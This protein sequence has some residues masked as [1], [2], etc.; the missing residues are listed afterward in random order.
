MAREDPALAR[1]PARRHGL[2]RLHAGARARVERA[3]ATTSPSSARSRTPSAT[4]SAAREVVR[5]DVGGLLPVFVL[6]RY[7]G[8]EVKL[9]QECSRAEL[10]D[11]VERERGR[12]PRAAAGRPRLREPR[13]PRRPG[14]RRDRRAA[15]PSRRTARS[16]STRCA[17]TPSS[18]PGG[19]RRSTGAEAVFVGSAHI[20]EVL[21]D[22]VGHVDRVH[23]VPPGVDIDEWRPRPRDEAL[24]GLLAEARRD[25]PNPGNASERLPDEGNAERLADVPRRRRARPSSTSGSSSTTRASTSCSR[26]CA[27]V[28]ARAVIVGFGDYREELERARRPAHALHRPAR[29]PAPRPPARARGRH[30]RPVDL[31]GG[32]RD[33]RRRGRRR[34]LAAARR[35]PLRPRRDRGGPGAG[36]PAAPA[37]T[38]RASRPA[39]RRSSRAS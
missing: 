7:E 20:R 16:S 6:D 37:R 5:P 12:G 26:R 27:S 32:V 30:G 8:Y 2:E 3:R 24:A 11:W 39:T 15:S 17:A 10:D 19:G 18:R 29:A 4:T 22:V 23:E 25:P 21:E 1:L 38:S 35:A 9:V 13:P 36:V 28:D 34:R 31:P 14:R 33:G